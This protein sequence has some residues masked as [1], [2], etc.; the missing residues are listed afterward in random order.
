MGVSKYIPNFKQLYLMIKKN[1]KILIN[2]KISFFILFLGPIFLLM[3]LGL[4]YF[5]ENS[6]NFQIGFVNSQDFDLSDGNYYYFL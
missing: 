5:N 2:N 3:I 1:I 6:Y 4:L